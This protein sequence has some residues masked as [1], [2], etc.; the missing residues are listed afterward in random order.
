MPERTVIEP[1]F[2]VDIAGGACG[3]MLGH[4]YVYNCRCIIVEGGDLSEPESC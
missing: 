2:A 4:F 1:G 3:W